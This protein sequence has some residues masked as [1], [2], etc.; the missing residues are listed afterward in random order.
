MANWCYNTVQFSADD[1][2]MEE[3]KSLFNAMAKLEEETLRGQLPTFVTSE[4]GYLFDIRVEEGTIYYA[5][6]WVPNTG[7]LTQIADHFQTG[8]VQEYWESGMWIY[9][10]ANYDQGVLTNTS[11][12]AMDFELF[13][14]DERDGYQFEGQSY[15]TEMEIMELLLERKKEGTDSSRGNGR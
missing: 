9:G 12:D 14:Y 2:K 7:I 3:I 4:D 10:E 13:E 5:T 1:Q 6:K 8:F 15:E 11:L